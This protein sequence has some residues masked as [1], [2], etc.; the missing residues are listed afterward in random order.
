M[1]AGAVRIDPGTDIASVVSGHGPNTTFWLAA[2]THRVRSAITTKSGDR[3]LGASGAVLD[4]AWGGT[5]AAIAGGD[6]V[7]IEGLVVQR[8]G[9]T[10]KASNANAAILNRT[11][12]DG[13][14]VTD[15]VVR[16][17]DGIGLFVG[18]N[19]IVEASCFEKNGQNGV[20]APRRGPT[21]YSNP[22]VN[23]RVERSAFFNNGRDDGLDGACG[24]C[25]SAMKFWA[26][27]TIKVTD[28][29]VESNRLG[30]WFDTNNA[31][32]I[33]SGN[34]LVSNDGPGVMIETSYNA[35]VLKNTFRK[36][37]LVRGAARTDPFPDAGLYISESGGDSRVPGSATFTVDGNTFDGDYNAITVWENPD[38]FCGS[39]ADE[40]IGSCSR[41]SAY[42]ATQCEQ[43]A[44]THPSAATFAQAC[45][46]LSQNIVISANRF[47]NPPTCTQAWC[48]RISL[49]SLPFGG[50]LKFRTGAS[51][52]TGWPQD[53][54]TSRLSTSAVVRNNSFQGTW[55]ASLGT[56]YPRLAQ[57]PSFSSNT[58]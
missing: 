19:S 52:S 50:T 6:N 23:A 28:N 30:I 13:W 54:I 34:E 32:S 43:L 42:T 40:S 53:V 35:Q 29:L 58:N 46:W 2:G 17:I 21:D 48:A 4:G 31:D 27:T 33:I 7:T 39:V 56:P 15:T 3:I 9:V 47:V 55:F 25:S 24:G 36:N 10:N 16:D 44:G 51:I 38:R 41:A 20:A 1:P 22:V 14:H 5:Y 11:A 37:S 45:R 12:A 57:P 26:T 8:F 18:S 49:V